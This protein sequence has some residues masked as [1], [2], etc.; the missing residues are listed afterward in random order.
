VGRNGW[1]LSNDYQRYSCRFTE[2]IKRASSIG[3]VDMNEAIVEFLTNIKKRNHVLRLFDKV[4]SLT[5][6]LVCDQ[7][8][9]VITFQHGEALVLDANLEEDTTCQISGELISL[10][11]LF[12][13]EEKL[14]ILAKQGKLVVKGTFRTTLL[15]ESAFYLVRT[16]KTEELQIF[17]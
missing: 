12:K 3:V 1:F 10:L 14:R 2:Y 8:A 15:L 9:A 7:Q 17:T 13:G 11:A 5:V 6:K 16:D 4:D